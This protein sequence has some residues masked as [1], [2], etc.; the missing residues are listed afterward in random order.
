MI[1]TVQKPYPFEAAHTYI[2]GSCGA[3]GAVQSCLF[4]P[5]QLNFFEAVYFLKPVYFSKNNTEKLQKIFLPS[6]LLSL[7][8]IFSFFFLRPYWDLNF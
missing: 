8:P 2:A 7:F 1:K 4:F 6:L 5:N 3:L